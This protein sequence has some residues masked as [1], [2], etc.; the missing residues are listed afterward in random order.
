MRRLTRFNQ[1]CPRVHVNRSSVY[2]LNGRRL[3][4]FK[5]GISIFQ[6]GDKETKKVVVK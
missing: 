3:T 1:D 2:D 4:T 6:T 5:K